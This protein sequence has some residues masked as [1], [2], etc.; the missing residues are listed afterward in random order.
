MQIAV[1]ESHQRTL[2]ERMFVERTLVERM[3]V[4]RTFVE[5]TLRE[6]Q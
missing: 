2:V 4:E 6:C 1:K 3:F 5:R